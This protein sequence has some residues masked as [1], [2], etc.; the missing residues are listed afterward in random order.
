MR[1]RSTAPRFLMIAVAAASCALVGLRPANAVP[2]AEGSTVPLRGTT[3]AA[4]PE[5][6]GTVIAD[7]LL[8]VEI[9]LGSVGRFRGSLQN[10]VVREAAG[11]LTFYYRLIS[12]PSST[13][14]PNAVSDFLT[15]PAARLADV[16]FRIDG[17]GTIPPTSATRDPGR[18]VFR[19]ASPV[20][21]GQQSRF[22]FLRTDAT[23][24]ALNTE[25]MI[26]GES[27]PYAYMRSLGTWGPV[28]PAGK[29]GKGM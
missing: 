4:R 28:Y 23:S 8:P 11:N 7:Q 9:D 24:Y 17:L 26:T 20:G 1:F 14:T 18:L 25:T 6:G 2:I 10:R 29:P 15:L 19:F 21:V 12:D 22:F 16:D 27:G 5:L 3:H 13:L